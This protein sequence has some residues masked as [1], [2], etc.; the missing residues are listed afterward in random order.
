VLKSTL[1]GTFWRA[2]TLREH[3]WH[4]RDLS[5]TLAVIRK[6][7]G[8]G[9]SPSW[10]AA[11]AGLVETGPCLRL[12]VDGDTNAQL[13]WLERHD[14]GYLLTYP[15]L[16]AELATLSLERGVKLPGLREVRSLGE[17]LEI[18]VRHL[19]K[20]AWNVPLTDIYS[21]EE[22]GY[23]ALQCPDHEHY[24]VQ[25]ENVLVE[26]LNEKGKPCAPGETG[27]VVVTDLHNFAMP[28]IR[29]DIG[30]YAEV[31]EPCPCGRGLPVLRRLVGRASRMLMAP[32]GTRY[33]PALGLR[34]LNDLVPLRQHQ[35]VQKSLRLVEVR[36]VPV[37]PL[38]DAVKHD[39]QSRIAARLPAGMQLRLVCCESIPR[40]PSGKHEEFISEIPVSR[41]PR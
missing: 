21:S 10:G 35:I 32:D 8:R 27:R 39:V 16:A 30:D 9:S 20:Q 24:H 7:A 3:R 22:V 40:A 6:G 11:T 28:V 17:S 33:W 13:E 5:V 25:A 15:S 12:D 29:Y 38:S 34:S 23:V 31:G 19:C 36:L 41:A 1:Q 37:S 2:L 18:G 14:P 4:R 26:V